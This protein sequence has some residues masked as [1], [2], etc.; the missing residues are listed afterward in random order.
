MYKYLSFLSI[1]MIISLSSISQSNPTE[2]KVKN[3]LCHK[4]KAI[5]IEIQGEKELPEEDL[6]ITFLK[7]GTFIDSQE[8]TNPSKEKWKYNHEKMTLTTGD[9]T[10]KILTITEQVLKLSSK[11]AD[12]IVIVTLKRVN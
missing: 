10:K 4:W 12:E 2:E 11:M 5:S 1:L 3:M 8:G 6:Y 7:D 9:V